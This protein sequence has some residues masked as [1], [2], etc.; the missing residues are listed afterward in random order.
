MRIFQ[1]ILISLSFL[2]ENMYIY[3]N[4][5]SSFFTSGN[6]RKRQQRR[7]EQE[8]KSSPHSPFIKEEKDKEE[9]GGM[10][11][12]C[13]P[14]HT[15]ESTDENHAKQT[16]NSQERR[17]GFININKRTRRRRIDASRNAHLPPPFYIFSKKIAEIW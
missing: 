13:A 1:H 7:K 6:S 5:N 3:T 8:E 17:Y 12:A 4:Q 11:S 9:R 10:G 2:P 16:E 14:V 15:R